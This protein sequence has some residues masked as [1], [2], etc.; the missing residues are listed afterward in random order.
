METSTEKAA[1]NCS[2]SVGVC[3]LYTLVPQYQSTKRFL[4]FDEAARL[5]L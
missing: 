5:L 1:V 2:V 3:V 4:K